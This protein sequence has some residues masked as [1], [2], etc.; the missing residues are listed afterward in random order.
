MCDCITGMNEI[1][2]EHNTRITP[3][4]A[5]DKD[6]GIYVVQPMIATEKIDSRKRIGPIKLFGDYCPFCGKQ[7]EEKSE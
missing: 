6:A 2:A 4:F 7:R 3:S 5:F 1:L